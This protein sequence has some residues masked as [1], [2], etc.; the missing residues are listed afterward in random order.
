MFIGIA[1]QY[2]YLEIRRQLRSNEV[3][4]DNELMLVST[5]LTTMQLTIAISDPLVFYLKLSLDSVQIEGT[6]KQSQQFLS[7]YVHLG[8]LTCRV[9]TNDTNRIDIDY[10][11]VPSYVMA[12]MEKRRSM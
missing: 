7:L 1:A 4:A 8:V 6:N 11:Q 9:T 2:V 5:G 10:E 3:L 12:L